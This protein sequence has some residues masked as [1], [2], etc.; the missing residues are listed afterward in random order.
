VY[1]CI[2]G[3]VEPDSW[4]CMPQYWTIIEHS[5]RKRI[6]HTLLRLCVPGRDLARHSL[7]SWP[8]SDHAHCCEHAPDRPPAQN[9][10]Y[11]CLQCLRTLRVP[12]ACG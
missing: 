2:A 11:V 4:A 10:D 8:S 6:D 9:I 12:L 5:S 3:L 1:S 7:R